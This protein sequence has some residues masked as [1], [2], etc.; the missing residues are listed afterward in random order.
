MVTDPTPSRPGPAW[1]PIT[2][3]TS[4][5]KAGSQPKISRHSS[6]RVSAASES[7]MYWTTQASAPDS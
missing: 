4:E 7:W 3:P 2:G 5:M 6:A 1:A